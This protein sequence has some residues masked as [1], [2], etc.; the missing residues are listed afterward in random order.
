MEI[1]LLTFGVFKT[2]AE[3]LLATGTILGLT[4]LVGKFIDPLKRDK[5]LPPVACA[6]GIGIAVAS[7]LSHGD[8]VTLA[9]VM[10][11]VV[12]GGSVTGLYSV[13]KEMKATP[14]TVISQ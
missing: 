11:G 10:V 13:A 7:Q 9:G 14:Q 2:A 6:L 1:D 3:L 5:I 4:G 8:P 12:F